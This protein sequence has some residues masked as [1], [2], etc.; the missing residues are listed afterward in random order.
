M[1]YEEI[2]SRLKAMRNPQN[3]AGMAR[4]GISPENTLGVSIPALREIAKSA[5]KDH[6]LA[7]K[8]WGSGL[9]EARILASMVD[10]PSKVTE[11]QMEKWASDFNS[12]DV[13]D[14]A[15]SNL[16]DK[17]RFA[18][19]KAYEWAGRKEEY[20]KRAA[21][22][23]MAALAVHDKKADGA[24]FGIFLEVIRREA[25]DERNFVK[26]AVNWALRQIGKR[27]PELRKE[28]ILS[29]EE[30]YKIDSPAARWVASD[31]LR[32]LG[33]KVP[34]QS[35]P[36]SRAQRAAQ[37]TRRPQQRSAQPQ[38]N[39]QQKQAQQREPVAQKPPQQMKQPTQNPPRFKP[40]RNLD[41]IFGAR[42]V[43]IIGASDNPEKLGTVILKNFTDGGYGGRIFPVNPKH[44]ALLNLACYPDV[45]A[46]RENVDCAIIA[47]PAQ[48]A[49]QIL[50]Q[51]AK[52][53]IKGVVLL[54]GGFGEVGN[55]DLENQIAAIC[56]R[57]EIALI[58][59]N[60]LGVLNPHTRI[61][62]IFMPF[63][64]FQ[65]PPPGSIAFVTQSG[66]VGSTI[67]DL[68]ASYGLGISKFIS[69]GNGALLNEADFLEYLEGDP[70]TKSIIL[71][72]EGAKE[73]RRL[74]EAL[75][76]A[77][78]RK[79]IIVLKAGRGGR[80][81]EAARSHTGNLA[82]NY[83]AYKAAFRQA[84]VVEAESLEELFDFVKIF[85]QPLPSG[86]RLGV[87][88]NG[89]GIGVLTADAAEREGM[90]L[91][92][93]GPKTF[94]AAKSILPPYG[95]PGNPLD[96]IADAGVEKYAAAIEAFMQDD[97]I[98][99]VIIDV[100]F[101]VPPIDERLLKTLIRASD[102]RRKPIAVVAMGGAYTERQRRTLE[103]NG[104]PTYSNPLSA[105]KAL[106]KLAEYSEYRKSL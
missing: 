106:K 75:K 61:D 101:Q 28:A 102:D 42:S 47:T 72:L 91:A 27:S 92:L 97:A 10:E 12:W 30:I 62:S 23:L 2:I 103:G 89:G 76:K 52:K 21:F 54:S 77:N 14:Q 48:T 85:E 11:S 3:A 55:R 100:L 6:A 96:L 31:A 39:V 94:K 49:P 68:A 87:I 16:F 104:V 51:C 56:G 78:R 13:C 58:G 60:C 18:Y 5:G 86:K 64:K 43:A 65:R 33:G 4:F 32:E 37:E 93:L 46:I 88:T 84:K 70:K 98:D 24:K 90:E 57:N 66:G 73:G 74:F 99:A 40:L 81:G 44:K 29:A 38:R 34:R 22:A 80:S 82:G 79:P 95:T 69:Y 41:C 63:Y 71:Y 67:V 7:L 50:Q 8:L 105:V 15:C 35:A 17:T 45:L 36:R 20:V 83:L 9:H 59:P 25:R 19:Q 53:G 26:K 1:K